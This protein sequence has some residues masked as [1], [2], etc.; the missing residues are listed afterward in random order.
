MFPGW[1]TLAGRAA[2]SRLTRAE[3][4]RRSLCAQGLPGMRSLL[5]GLM[6]PRLLTPADGG[7]GSRRRHFDTATTFHAFLW[8]TLDGQASCRE[9]VQQVQLA[10][11]A[12]G[13]RP[14]PGSST[15][16]YCQARSRMD[17]GTGAEAATAI[18]REMDRRAASQDRW[19]GREVKLLD[20]TGVRM[21]DTPEARGIFGTPTGQ[22]PG[23]GFPVMK[24]CALFSLT[25]GAWLAHETG[26][27]YDHDLSCALPL[28][29]G[30]LASGDVLVADRAYSAWWVMAIAVS[31]GADCVLRLHQSRRADFR[32]GRP[33]G[34]GDRLQV[35]PK[36]PRSTT[37]P[38]SAEQYAALPDALEVRMVRSTAALPGERVREMILVTTLRDPVRY[39][40]DALAA[41]FR[42]RWQIELNF[43]DIKT[44]LGMNHLACRSAQMALRMVN[45]YR[46]AYNLIRAQMQRTAAHSGQSLYR[47]SFTA[48]ARLLSGTGQW[49]NGPH[50]RTPAES[51]R[52]LLNE[53][54]AG[55]PVPLRP[56]RS[57]P[58]AIKRRPSQYPLMTSYRNEMKVIPHQK[59]YR[60][61]K[62]SLTA[63][64]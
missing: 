38:L 19:L 3:E 62:S 53:L 34:D 21:D 30:H 49:L 40:V 20:A 37:C 15:S 54:I 6:D 31:L 59:K 32:T 14:L 55:D 29:T 35:W 28:L 60:R 12:T 22:K 48:A 10:R 50:R 16:A 7:P 45:M 41:I 46:C 4:Q 64:S 2:K 56:G 42:R 36:P 44:T 51:V 25:T 47:M 52:E 8:Q 24:L 57:D 5:E 13:C 26:R 17:P 61:P 9:A 39:P 43:D 27:T 11:A 58:R 23:C 1:N 18:A 33:L 63:L